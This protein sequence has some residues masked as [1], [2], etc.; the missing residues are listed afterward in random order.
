M[1]FFVNK[2]KL[3]KHIRARTRARK[4]INELQSPLV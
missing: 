3:V 2:V 4:N 1:T